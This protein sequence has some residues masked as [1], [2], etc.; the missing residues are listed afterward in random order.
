MILQRPNNQPVNR[1]ILHCAAVPTGWA[2]KHT[3]Q[4]AAIEVDRWH[5]DRG[6]KGI[7]YHFVVMPDGSIALGRSVY[8][9]GAHTIGQNTGSIGILM[10]EHTGIERLEPSPL[11]HFSPVQI[12]AVKGIISTLDAI[13]PKLLVKGHNDYDRR[14]CPSF[15]VVPSEWRPMAPFRG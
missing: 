6:W 10:V 4:T 13:N 3:A 2:D 12:A 9:V 15:K 5:K 7:G 14:L 1:V 11:V 8:D